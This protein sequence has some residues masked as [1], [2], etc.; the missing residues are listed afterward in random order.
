VMIELTFSVSCK[1]MYT[2]Y[3]PYKIDNLQ[4]HF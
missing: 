2:Y 1:F 4:E 3:Y